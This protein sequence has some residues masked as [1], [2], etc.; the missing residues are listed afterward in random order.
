MSCGVGGIRGSDLMLLWLAAVASTGP[1]AWEPPYA[2]GVVLESKK[3]KE[4]KKL[5]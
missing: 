5:H 1:L 3:E 2:V 4:K